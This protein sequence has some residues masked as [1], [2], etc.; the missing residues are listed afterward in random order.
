LFTFGVYNNKESK[1]DKH[2]PMAT[3]NTTRTRSLPYGW[4]ARLAELTGYSQPTINRVIRDKDTAHTVWKAFV[5]LLE[6]TT[7][8]KQEQ[9]Q[10]ADNLLNKLTTA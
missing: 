3:K 10:Y 7:R 4:N 8:E 9:V 2:K 5:Q 1:N 6:E